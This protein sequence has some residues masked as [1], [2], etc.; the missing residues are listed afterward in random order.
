MFDLKPVLA[1]ARQGIETNLGRM[2]QDGQYILGRQTSKFEVELAEMLGGAAAVGVGT[3]TSAIELCLRDAGITG[4]G[5]DVIVPAMTSLFTAQAILAAGARLRVADV[6]PATL[7]L[8]AERASAAWTPQTAAVV[9]VHLY[10][11]PCRLQELAE[12]CRQRGAVL[13]QDACQAHGA[14]AGDTPLTA[15]SPYCAYSFYPTKNLGG[16]GDGGAVVTSDP[17]IGARLRMLRDGGRQGDQIC[18]MP[19]VNSRLD[20]MQACYLRALLPNLP[21]WNAHRRALAE[22]YRQNLSGLRD[23]TLLH[24]DQDSVHHLFVVRLRH[25]DSV[26]A[27]LAA[28][29][30]QTGIHYPVPLHLQPGFRANSSWRDLPEEAERAA[31]GI[32]SL[33]IGPHVTCGVAAQ[34]S[35]I[36]RSICQ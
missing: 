29:G 4:R 3:G 9:A 10:G 36:L 33:P 30:V 7:L 32:L 24:W 5:Q 8:D 1:A 35:S 27:A 34:I 12:L 14:R 11:Q 21:V 18:R 31:A 23:L 6:D 15:Y 17:E 13:I 20:E 2:H 22:V 19:A 25:R 28:S 16:L 26:K